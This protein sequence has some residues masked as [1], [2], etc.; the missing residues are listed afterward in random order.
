MTRSSS[1]CLPPSVMAFCI[2][3]TQ[4]SKSPSWPQPPIFAAPGPNAQYWIS[5]GGRPVPAAMVSDDACVVQDQERY[6]SDQS[7]ASEYGDA[8]HQVVSLSV[9][10]A[11]IMAWIA[12]TMAMLRALPKSLSVASASSS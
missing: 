10:A 1:G 3:R 2:C 7:A 8:A 6:D 11:S 9:R 12:S 4:E 5:A